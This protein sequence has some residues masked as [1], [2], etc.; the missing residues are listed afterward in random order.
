MKTV[1]WNSFAGLMLSTLFVTPAWAAIP[2]LYT[3]DNFWSSEHDQPVSFVGDGQGNF[4]GTTLTGKT[5]TQTAIENSLNVRIHKFLIDEA[6]FYIT[7]HGVIKAETDIA[8]LS[9]YLTQTT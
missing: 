4:Y 2:A 9:I 5:F 6:F 7:D 1:I 3:N 8:A